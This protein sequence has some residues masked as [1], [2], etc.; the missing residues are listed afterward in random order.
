MIKF[1][2]PANG[3]LYPFQVAMGNVDGSSY[4]PC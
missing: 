2:V 4:H 1:L 3:F